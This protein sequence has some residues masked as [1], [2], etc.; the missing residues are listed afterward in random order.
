MPKRTLAGLFGLVLLLLAGGS[1]AVAAG[2]AND[3]EAAPEARVVQASAPGIRMAAT[4]EPGGDLVRKRGVASVTHPATGV[5][6]ITPKTRIAMDVD[7]VV[8][9]V[10]VEYGQSSG[11]ANL[12]QIYASAGDCDPGA[13]Q[14]LTF[15]DTGSGFEPSDSV[16]FNLV[17]P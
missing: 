13:V 4:I 6:C 9:Q 3:P 1:A 10:T 5:Y 7:R 11:T 17:V 14:V 12:A 15:S 16:A 8:A 2:R